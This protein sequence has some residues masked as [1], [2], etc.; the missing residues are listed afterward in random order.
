LP[1]SAA[2]ERLTF[3]PPSSGLA[4][5]RPARINTAA[6]FLAQQI[7]QENPGSDR[8]NARYGAE[9]VIRQYRFNMDDDASILGPARDLH[10][11]I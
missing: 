7:S 9:N 11:I 8:K 1:W 10:K 3:N 4:A 6:A 5:Y 2:A